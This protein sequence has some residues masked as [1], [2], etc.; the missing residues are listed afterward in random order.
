MSAIVAKY[1]AM[2]GDLSTYE[3]LVNCKA[4]MAEAGETPLL[5][6]KQNVRLNKKGD[7]KYVWAERFAHA[8]YL[9]ITLGY[10]A[11]KAWT[12]SK[13]FVGSKKDL[14]SDLYVG[15]VGDQTL[16][17]NTLVSVTAQ[18]RKDTEGERAYAALAAAQARVDKYETKQKVLIKN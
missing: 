7:A 1:A 5:P 8:A 4:E 18:N 15:S 16:K 2:Q 17:I 11:P 9:H 3:D 12:L 10:E 6:A 13:D 14:L